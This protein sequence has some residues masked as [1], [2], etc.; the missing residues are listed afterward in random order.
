MEMTFESIRKFIANNS[1]ATAVEY[2][3]LCVLIACAIVLAV[4]GLGSQLQNTYN[5]VGSNLK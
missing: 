4:Q 3:L 2:A 5:E 1:G